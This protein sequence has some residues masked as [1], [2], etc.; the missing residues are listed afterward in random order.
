MADQEAAT[1]EP[2]AVA[3]DAIPDSGEAE[4]GDAGKRAIQR[5]REARKELEARLKEMEPL[6]AKARELEEAQKSE[7][8]RL[9]ERADNAEKLAAETQRELMRLRVASEKG[10]PPKLAA[11]LT[12]N[13]IE[14]LEADADEL[15]NLV[16][17]KKPSASADDTLVGTRTPPAAAQD[18]DA[19]VD[20]LRAAGRL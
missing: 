6:V 1:P 18:V 4:L 19:I 13:T 9:Q 7:T 10:L 14:E 20:K 17:T 8:Q 11:R 5:E 2:V 16:P 15:L 12:G 3:E